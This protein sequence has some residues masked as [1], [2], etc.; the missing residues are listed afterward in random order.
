MRASHADRELV[1]DIL[2]VATGEGRITVAELDERLEAAFTARTI[3]ELA[4]LTADLPG[5]TSLRTRCPEHAG[6][7]GDRWRVLRSL[8]DAAERSSAS[9]AC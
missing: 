9:P 5:G 7:P 4:A 6:S 8:L 2:R 3:G 1:V